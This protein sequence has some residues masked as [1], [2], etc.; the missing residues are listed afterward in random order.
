VRLSQIS[1]ELYRKGATTSDAYQHCRKIGTNHYENFTV[2]SRLLPRKKRKYVY[3]LYAFSRYTDD[4]GDELEDG[5]SSAL[6]QWEQEL[7]KSIKNGTTDNL[8]LIALRDTVH[9]LDLSL[10][11]LKK[12][13]HAN[14]MDQLNNSYE[15]YEDLLHYCDHSANPVGRIFL[16]IFDESSERNNALSDKTCTGLQLTN[17]WQDVNR[18]EKMGRVYIPVEDM[19]H[20]NYSREKLEKRVYNEN[21][22]NL[23]KFEVNRARKLLKEGFTLVPLLEGRIKIDVRLFNLGG[24]KILNKI[25]QI[26]YD[27]LHTR[28]TISKFEK[29]TLFSLSLLDHLLGGAIYGKQP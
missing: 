5:N 17:F 28:P 8:I 7:E 19:E 3:A 26:N 4:L 24:L 21:F 10:E 25:G 2:V 6:D 27:V 22:V 12:I 23:M 16:K 18:D 29:V 13:I 11:W 20:F 1:P 15:T 14:R 9:E